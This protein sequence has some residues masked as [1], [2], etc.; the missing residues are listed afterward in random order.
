VTF[1]SIHSVIIYVVFFGA[2]M[3]CT[4]LCSLNPGVTH[5]RAP[6]AGGVPSAALGGCWRLGA[7]GWARHRVAASW[8]HGQRA[9]GRAGA[10]AELRARGSGR[11]RAGGVGAGL[12]C[13]LA[14][15]G[16]GAGLLAVC[17]GREARGRRER[18]RVGRQWERGEPGAAAA[19]GM[20]SRG[21]AAGLHEP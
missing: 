13:G 21:R 14:R 3:R 17:L 19:T 15:G 16:P 5:G 2:C 1:I 18:G 6:R 10:G 20:G 8:R 11:L 7:S 12:G 9:V 4:R